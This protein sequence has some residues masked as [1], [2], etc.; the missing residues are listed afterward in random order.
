M[1]LS[2]RHL[3]APRRS[4]SG[5][6]RPMSSCWASTGSSSRTETRAG[7]AEPRTT[8]SASRTSTG[9]AA[10][11]PPA[12]CWSGQVWGALGQVTEPLAGRVGADLL[13]HGDLKEV[14]LVSLA[15][16]LWPP[17]LQGVGQPAGPS[18][19][20]GT[21]PG[22]CP[23]GLSSGPPPAMPGRVSGCREDS[24]PSRG[25]PLPLTHAIQAR[26]PFPWELG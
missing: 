20:S 21:M 14:V 16:W 11:Q 10:P 26:G 17:S 12:G 7:C 19:F 23:R 5:L 9:E 24:H 13:G 6:S 8:R 22:P 1:G 2:S 25:A 4:G 3:R 18:S 15:S